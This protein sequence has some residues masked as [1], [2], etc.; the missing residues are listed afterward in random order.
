MNMRPQTVQP[1]A[2]GTFTGRHMLLVMFGFFGIVIAVNAVMAVAA[3]TTWSGLVVQNSYV[4]SQEFQRR[5]DALEKQQALGWAASFSYAPGSVHFVIRDGAGNPV[6]L[7]A[8]ALQVNRPVGTR[9]DQFVQLERAPNGDYL[10]ALD[11]APGTWDVL[12]ATDETTQGPF[13]FRERFTV[14][15]NQ[16]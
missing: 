3:S 13:E 12:I 9:D 8:I 16:P 15:A 10:A 1:P 11:L 5:H 14:E 6:D 2:K 4:A 7:G